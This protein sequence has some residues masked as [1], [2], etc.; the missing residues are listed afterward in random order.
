MTRF[1]SDNP[2]FHRWLTNMVFSMT[3]EEKGRLDE[4]GRPSLGDRDV[5]TMP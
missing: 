4:S 2:D 3:Y 1:S 5:S